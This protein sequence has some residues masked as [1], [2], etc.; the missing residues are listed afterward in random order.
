M[1]AF[2]TKLIELLSLRFKPII[3]L[4]RRYYIRLIKRELTLLS[5]NETSRV[6][7]IGCGALPL[8]AELIYKQAHAKIDMIDMDI[9]MV[10]GCQRYLQHA[11]LPFKLMH[12]DAAHC[13]LKPY[14]HIIVAKQ[15]HA[16][17]TLINH[18]TASS[19]PNTKILI[20]HAKQNRLISGLTD[21][22]EVIRS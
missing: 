19:S 10:N 11:K 4:K 22:V 7:F 5:I 17:Q 9:N 21:H 6:L 13:P 8:S 1:V 14:T 18:L 15:V 2:T 3:A 12:C 16:D 20:R